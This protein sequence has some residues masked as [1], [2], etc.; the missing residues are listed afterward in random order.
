MEKHSER[1]LRV[2]DKSELAEWEKQR[3][4]SGVRIMSL[5]ELCDPPRIHVVFELDRDN[6][7]DILGYVP[8]GA[9]WLDEGEDEDTVT[10]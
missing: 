1:T 6:A 8:E 10:A 3:W 5:D 9:E 2:L 4:W 7:E